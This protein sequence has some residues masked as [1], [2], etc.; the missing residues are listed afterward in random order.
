[1]SKIIKASQVVGKYEIFNGKKV[2]DYLE[3]KSS[4]EEV[5]PQESNID[6][7]TLEEEK[8]KIIADAQKKADRIIE[9]AEEK[10]RLAKKIKSECRQKGLQEGKEKGFESGYE[11]GLQEAQKYVQSLKKAVDNF[12]RQAEE[13]MTELKSQLI[14]LSTKIANIIVNSK[15]DI[16]PDLINNII[17]DLLVDMGK[18]HQNLIIKVNPQML[19]YINK[20][21]FRDDFFKDN[22]KFIAD[23]SL[24]K[25]DCIVDTNFG[26]KDAI[27]A[28]KLQVLEE[29]LYKEAGLHEET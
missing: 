18:N 6:G 19:H 3:K 8:N 9:E 14:Q 22:L 28:D 17:E 26:G 10:K 12:N 7:S 15:L 29:K 13:R 2:K 16:N 20:D 23:N 24:R 5:S 25:G 4:E 1:M 27:I 11:E 21:K